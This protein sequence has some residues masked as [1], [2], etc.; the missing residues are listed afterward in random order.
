MD[1]RALCVQYFKE[2]LDEIETDKELVRSLKHHE[3]VPMFIDNLA[4]SLYHLPVRVSK[5]TI[6]TCVFDLTRI[7]T[8]CL[9]IR[10][11][12]MYMSD[13]EKSLIKKKEEEKMMADQL[14]DA[15]FSG[16]NETV[17]QDEKGITHKETVRI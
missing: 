9:K 16:Q 13:L 14:A 17:T 4:R 1:V 12:E 7:F 5:Q 11:K 6:R 3:R 10:A 2:Y 8:N 15:I